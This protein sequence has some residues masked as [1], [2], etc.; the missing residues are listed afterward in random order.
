MDNENDTTQQINEIKG[1]RVVISFL[2]KSKV[3]LYVIK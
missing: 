1:N 2:K 3:Q